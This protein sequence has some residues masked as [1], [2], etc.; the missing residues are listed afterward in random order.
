[1]KMAQENE[2]RIFSKILTKKCKI[3]KRSWIL[4]RPYKGVTR[5]DFK[6]RINGGSFILY[7]HRR[8]YLRFFS[9]IVLFRE[10]KERGGHG[11]SIKG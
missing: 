10:G 11:M 3:L 4:I 6:I 2:C 9:W 8:S 5:K 1:M 7:T